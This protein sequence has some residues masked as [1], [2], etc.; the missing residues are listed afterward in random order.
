MQRA[1]RGGSSSAFN[2]ERPPLSTGETEVLI[3]FNCQKAAGGGVSGGCAAL[4]VER[5]DGTQQ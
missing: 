3:P 1:V 2:Y 4:I 5:E